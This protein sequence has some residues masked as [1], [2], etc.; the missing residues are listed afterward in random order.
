MKNQ[1][2]A[3]ILIEDLV[4]QYPNAVGPLIKEGIVCIQCGEPLWGTL[5]EA[6]ERK[7]IKQIDKIVQDLNDTLLK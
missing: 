7:G 3:D 2:K 1:I 6:A 4:S 5:R